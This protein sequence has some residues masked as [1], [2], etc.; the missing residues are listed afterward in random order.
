MTRSCRSRSRVRSSGPVSGSAEARRAERSW[1][2]S[3][4]VADVGDELAECARHQVE[5]AGRGFDGLAMGAGGKHDQRHD[6]AGEGAERDLEHAVDR[7]FER[8]VM[9][10]GRQQQHDHRGDR[11]DVHARID[12]GQ[13]CQR[14]HGQRQHRKQGDLAVMGDQH[15]D[16]A[17]ID[18]TAERADHVVDGGAQ[19]AADARLGQDQRGH[20]HPQRQ[21]HVEG[22]R[23]RQ[24]QQR[25]DGDAQRQ[26]QLGPPPVQA[27][28]EPGGEKRGTGKKR[29]DPGSD[30]MRPNAGTEM[31]PGPDA[32]HRRPQGLPQRGRMN[33]CLLLNPSWPGLS[34]GCLPYGTPCG[35]PFSASSPGRR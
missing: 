18:R 14:S 24:R 17:A 1:P 8:A 22:E 28:A 25:R 33:W 11:R 9:G 10:D 2:A 3:A 31:P 34:R 26:H 16:G 29:Q 35:P 13:Q 5:R 21:R 6:E 32:S 19:R 30:V 15:G 23:Q 7:G 20:H 4:A 27:G 12:R